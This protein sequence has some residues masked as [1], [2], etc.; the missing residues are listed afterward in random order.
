[1][2]NDRGF[3][4]LAGATDPSKIEM[5]EMALD[6][7]P[8]H[9]PDRSRVLA[10]LCSELTYGSD[11]D[12]RKALAEEAMAIARAFDDDA[13]IVWVL[14]HVYVALCV[15]ELIEE[16][17]SRTAEALT[18]SERVGDP[19]LQFF[20]TGFRS[21]TATHFGD[22]DEAV[23][24]L[25]AQASLAKQLNQPMLD[26]LIAWMRGG[27][28]QINGS[29]DEAERL[30]NAALE[31]GT[32]AG[33]ED[34]LSFFGP[35]LIIVNFQRGTLSDLLPLVEQLEPTVPNLDLS[36]VFALVHV[37]GGRTEEALPYLREFASR[38]FTLPID[39]IWLLNMSC[40]AESIIQCRMAEYAEP[41]LRQL[42]AWPHLLANTGGLAAFGPVSHFLGGLACLLDRYDDAE[43]Y[44]R[45]SADFSARIGA[46][47]FAA[48]TNL[49]WGEMYATR[50]RDGDAE[51]ARNL[52]DAALVSASSNGYGVVEQRALAALRS[53]N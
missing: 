9:H 36:P 20:A 43:N 49:V 47:F 7:L 40:Y 30:A 6:R 29:I 45:Q 38:N 24:C 3:F 44:F 11:L 39:P 27:L 25:D 17:W 53:L 34:A 46:S 13:T 21:C 51:R 28:A 8:A 2:A 26:W 15:P 19:L 33:Q 18:R 48:R 32:E 52:F 31:L 23:R 35:Q 37:E 14:N 1:L 5:L 42:T 10:C 41:V 16:S 12:R 50:Q 4:S 22:V